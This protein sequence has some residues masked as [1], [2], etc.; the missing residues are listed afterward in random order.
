MPSD[1]QKKKSRA[2]SLKPSDGIP[3]KIPKRG[4]IP[5]IVSPVPHEAFQIHCAHD[6]VVKAVTLQPHPRNPNTHPE[7][8]IK[9]LSEI[10][11]RAGWRAPIVVSKR[12]GYVISGHG[13]LQ[14]ALLMGLE[15]VP[16][17]YQDFHSESDELAHLVADNRI[18]ELSERDSSSLRA[19]LA[20]IGAE[21]DL[22]SLGYDEFDLAELRV[23]LSSDHKSDDIEDLATELEGS[24]LA[25]KDDME[26]PSSLP[27]NI[28]ELRK[29]ML[30]ACPTDIDTWMGSKFC[31]SDDHQ[32][33]YYDWGTESTKGLDKAKMI[34]GFYTEDYVFECMWSD[35]AGSVAKM[36]NAKIMGSIVP[37]FSL[38]SDAPA[39][40]RIFNS[41]RN[42]WCGR[43]MQESGIRVIP[44]ISSGNKGEWEAF[45]APIPRHAPT[46]ALQ[47]ITGGAR[48]KATYSS[49]RADL[50]RLIAKLLPDSLL[51]YMGKHAP[52]I[53][54]GAIPSTCTLIPVKSRQ[55]R[56]MELYPQRKAKLAADKGK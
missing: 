10:I 42:H 8:Q 2:G 23:D 41:Y 51:V 11:K 6:A 28:P 31:Q 52:E 26:F 40:V 5:F 44:N 14:A 54:D 25:L 33:W 27:F 49:A 4:K 43:F 50:G 39:A 13:R 24:A 36:L 20:D 46:I 7:A 56:R 1:T 18:A 32:A 38:F 47:M 21:I 3:I 37:N 35:P 9:V 22:S 15:D 53:L 29:D 19:I 34:T 45:E 55:V 30:L 17:N 16:V 48:D 12:S